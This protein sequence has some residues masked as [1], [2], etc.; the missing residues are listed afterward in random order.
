ML[1]MS[2]DAQ[3][4]AA[5][6]A[7]AAHPREAVRRHQR[8]GQAQQLV[9]GAPT[10]ARTSST[11]ATTRMRTPSSWRS[12]WPS[13]AASTSMPTCSARASRTPA[14]TIAWARTRHR[15]RSSRSSSAR[16]SRTSS[17]SSSRARR[18]A[19]RRAA[20]WTLGVT[21]LPV[22]PTDATDRNRTSPFAF[23]GNKF[24]FRAVGSSAPIYWPQTVLNTAVADSL[25]AARGRAREARAGR[26]RGPDDDPVGDRQGAQAGPLRG[27]QLLRGMAR[28]GRATRAAEQQDHCRRTAG[29]QTT[30]AK[31]VFC[32]VRRP[33]R[34]RARGTR[35]H[36]L[37][38]L[39]QGPEHRGELRRST[40]RATMI[41]PA[42][43]HVPRPARSAAASSRGRQRP[44]CEQVVG[45]RGPLVAAI[46]GL[47]KAQHEA[48]EAGSVHS[49]AKAFV[50]KVIPAQDALREV[51]DE[52]ETRGRGRP[53]AAA[54]V[55]GAPLPVL[56]SGWGS[57]RAPRRR[58]AAAEYS[59]EAYA[60]RGLAP[61]TRPDR[62]TCR[63]GISG[64]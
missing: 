31:E 19:R 47:E 57:A 9:D 53:L 10:T 61:A 30:K 18:R 23:T 39:R 12:S 33:V 7:D 20:T 45:P 54:Q 50:D 2:H 6:R 32:D 55:P 16:S 52:L 38:A 21:S 36:H 26:L 51:A 29:A 41:L 56:I 25:D 28:G 8:L 49:E 63:T 15:R 24:E 13:S 42:A 35:R 4:R 3:A 48:H 37:G 58:R 62:Q 17:S 5:P 34:A 22:L 1:V 59:A 14:T 64:R 46:D 40:S 27:Q 44:S 60:C 11:R 43:V